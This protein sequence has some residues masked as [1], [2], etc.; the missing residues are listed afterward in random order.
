MKVQ[1]RGWGTEGRLR[2]GNAQAESLRISR[3]YSSVGR[4][5]LQAGL[6][7]WESKSCLWKAGRN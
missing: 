7:N 2:G 1:Q 6:G 3:S 4:K 5:S